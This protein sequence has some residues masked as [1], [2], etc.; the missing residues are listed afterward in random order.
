MPSTKGEGVHLALKI[1]VIR[2]VGY[3]KDNTF[4]KTRIFISQY[5]TVTYKTLIFRKSTDIVL[6][7]CSMVVGEFRGKAQKE[8]MFNKAVSE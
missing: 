7:G 2:K 6:N 4:A 1:L 3:R 8:Q 5:L